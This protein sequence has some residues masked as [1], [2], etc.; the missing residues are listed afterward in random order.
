MLLLPSAR[1]YAPKKVPPAE[2]LLLFPRRRVHDGDVAVVDRFKELGQRLP[3]LLHQ[4]L[5]FLVRRAL[6]QRLRQPFLG[7]AQS[8]LCIGEIAVLDAQRDVPQLRRH[9]VACASR[10]FALQAPV[11]G[12]QTQEDLQVLDE[13]LHTLLDERQRED[14]APVPLKAGRTVVE[15]RRRGTVTLRLE[16]VRCGKESCHCATTLMSQSDRRRP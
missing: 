2:V 9:A 12:P 13:A 3:E 16:Y 4:F 15:E 10:C 5:D 1:L 14:T 8:P 7:G 6:F 11:G